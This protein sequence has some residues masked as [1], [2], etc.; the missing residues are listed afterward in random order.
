MRQLK[1]HP[2]RCQRKTIHSNRP[3]LI[4]LP[5][6]RHTFV[7]IAAA[8]S[9][10]G[11]GSLGLENIAMGQDDESFAYDAAAV[12]ATTEAMKKATVFMTSQVAVHGGY[13]YDVSVDLKTRR[14]EGT[15]TASDCLLYTSPSPRDS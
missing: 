5:S 10:S 12:T 9:L 1:S 2:N 3:D 13:V 8:I 14:G 15:A 4:H 11:C 6:S 7:A